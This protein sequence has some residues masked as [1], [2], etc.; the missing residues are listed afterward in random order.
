M[1]RVTDADQNAATA[2]LEVAEANGELR[3]VAEKRTELESRVTKVE[4]ESGCRLI[5]LNTMM[6]KQ[7]RMEKVLR[8]V[9]KES[10]GVFDRFVNRHGGG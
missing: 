3:K 5:R 7:A 10:V 6:G 9:I 1:K 2:L 4:A 8:D